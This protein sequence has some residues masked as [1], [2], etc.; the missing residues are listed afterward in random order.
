[1]RLPSLTSPA[2]SSEDATS[3]ASSSE[4]A[5]SPASCSEDGTD[6][7]SEGEFCF[8]VVTLLE[9]GNRVVVYIGHAYNTLAACNWLNAA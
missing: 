7:V 8:C 9:E 3:P 2:S 4:D 6:S 5:T 1:M